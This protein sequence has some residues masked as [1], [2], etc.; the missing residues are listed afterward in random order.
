MSE[1]NYA[2]QRA[3]ILENLDGLKVEVDLEKGIGYLI[4]DRPPLN[5]VSYRGRFQIRALIE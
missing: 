2:L 5:I 3:S 4:L 1:K